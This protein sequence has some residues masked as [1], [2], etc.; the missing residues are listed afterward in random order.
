MIISFIREFITIQFCRSIYRYDW[1]VHFSQK[2]FLKFPYKASALLTNCRKLG[3]GLKCPILAL[4]FCRKNN[5]ELAASAKCRR[6]GEKTTYFSL[7]RYIG[8]QQAVCWFKTAYCSKYTFIPISWF[9][10]VFIHD[11]ES[12]SIV[13]VYT[14]LFCV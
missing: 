12:C 13:S 2:R 4:G 9:F 1:P 11:F 5:Q 8:Y 10:A 3:K 14:I 7:D 6:M